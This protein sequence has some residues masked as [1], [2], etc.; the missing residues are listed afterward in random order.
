MVYPVP[1]YLKHYMVYFVF[2]ERFVTAVLIE[3]LSRFFLLLIYA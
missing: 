1:A 2:D 3:V